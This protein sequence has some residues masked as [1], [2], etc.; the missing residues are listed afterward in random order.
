MPIKFESLSVLIVE[1]SPPM[2]ELV[3]GVMEVMGVKKIIT[4]SDGEAGYE[5]FQKE[6][7]DIV[8]TDWLMEP[9]D[10][11]EMTLKIRRDPL[12]VDRLVPVIV[13]T[14]FTAITRVEMAR[15]IGV[16]EFIVKPFTAKELARRIQHIIEKP[17]DFVEAQSFFG[18]D[19]RRRK[20]SEY[21]GPDRRKGRR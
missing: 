17:R 6:K 9:V 1:D 20:K 5:R 7:P 2:L 15:D 11:I 10:G 16:T 13:M 21:N 18:P 14:G 12:S 8:I 19:R 4:A 3:S